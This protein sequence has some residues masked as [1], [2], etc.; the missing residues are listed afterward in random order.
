MKK[1]LNQSLPIGLL[2]LFVFLPPSVYSWSES[3]E[4][5]K[6]ATDKVQ[7]IESS[8][9]QKK[10]LKILKR[11]LISKGK[12]YFQK[13]DSLRWEYLSPVPVVLM[14]HQGK[15]KRYLKKDGQFKEDI[16]AHLQAMQIVI[17]EIAHWLAGNFD[18]NP[19]F[20]PELLQKGT[21]RLTPKNQDMKDIISHIELNLSNQPGVIDTVWIHENKSSVTILDFQSAKIN[22]PIEESLF[23]NP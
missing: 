1:L 22:L 3:F 11:P 18:Q 23:Q 19:S 15:I 4:S 13:P 8:F 14:S 10:Q 20:N 2:V 16:G 9:I 17:Q 12:F 6:Q 5:I 7:S 21:I